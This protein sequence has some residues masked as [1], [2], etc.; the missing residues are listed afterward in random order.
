[1]I[2]AANCVRLDS[3]SGLHGTFALLSCQVFKQTMLTVTAVRDRHRLRI[4]LTPWV[5]TPWKMAMKV[6][7]RGH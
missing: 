5:T 1:M 2:T 6:D 4:L 7:A 3:C